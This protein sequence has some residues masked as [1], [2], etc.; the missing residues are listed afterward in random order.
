M[1]VSAVVPVHDGEEY[2]AECLESLR[3]QTIDPEAMEVIVVDDG[4][5]DGTL[6]LARR[7][8]ASDGR[9]RVIARPASGSAA[10]P[11]NAGIEAARGEY[12]MFVD[13]DDVLAPETLERLSGLG[14]RSGSDVI[15]GRMASFDGPE[16][17]VPTRMFDRDHVAES[18]IESGAYETL[19]PWKMFRR[20]T[21]ERLGL[22]F[23]TGF[24]IGED[25][26]FV[27]GAYLGGG[28]VSIASDQVYYRL[29]SRRD[30][31]NTV[32]IGQ[33]PAEY[34][35]GNLALVDVVVR[36]G[37]AD[38]ADQDL[39][40]ARPMLG[41]GG[42]VRSFGRD[43]LAL[44]DGEREALVRRAREGIRS[45]YGPALRAKARPAV[46]VL[47]DAISAGD[48]PTV[49]A[50]ARVVAD[51]GPLPVV[52]GD[53]DF[54]FR[55]AGRGYGD[56]GLRAGTTLEGLDV[57]RRR[58]VTTL[59]VEVPGL[60]AVPDDVRAVW[61]HRRSKAEVPTRT[62]TTFA[63]AEARA[64]ST[65]DIR[66]LDADA[67]WDLFCVVRWRGVH[68]RLRV[69]ARRSGDVGADVRTRRVLRRVWSAYFTPYGNLSIDVG[70]RGECA[71]L[72]AVQRA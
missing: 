33:S 52:P 45:A 25:R 65:L 4:S 12:L 44:P 40:V 34:L 16:R 60:D 51:G 31:G 54:E 72:P 20:S 22:R 46:R 59:R 6:A 55:G 47:L 62:V 68:R 71:G 13:A 29:R 61:V 67:D 24:R 70:H 50:V 17:P 41:R 64:T 11:R 21:V 9:F 36:A 35:E 56:L 18:A 7:F 1:K 3:S 38:R 14:D 69:G 23:P 57:D 10:A 26:P 43:Y 8:A 39:L 2:L 28:T 5:T 30:G 32:T 66:R 58:I 53:V 48:G 49:D 19:G 15:L 42:I 63:G 37:L 27:M